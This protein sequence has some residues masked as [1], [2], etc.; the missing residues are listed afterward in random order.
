[1]LDWAK[2][3]KLRRFYAYLSFQIWVLCRSIANAHIR[4]AQIWWP[5]ALSDCFDDVSHWLCHVSVL[6]SWYFKVL[7]HAVLNNERHA[8]WC[9][10]STLV[11]KVRFI[12]NQHPMDAIFALLIYNVVKFCQTCSC[13]VDIT[14][15]VSYVNGAVS[16]SEE[17]CCEGPLLVCLSPETSIDLLVGSRYCD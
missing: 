12:G 15:Q 2:T 7:A 11:S 8:V 16:F 1:M 6:S 4:V 13:T 14:S 3:S 17:T 5:P 10:H 9:K